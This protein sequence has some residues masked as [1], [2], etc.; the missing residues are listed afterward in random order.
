M[1]FENRVSAEFKIVLVSGNKR[2]T[3]FI[4]CNAVLCPNILTK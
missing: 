3:Q 4:L 2:L 1:E